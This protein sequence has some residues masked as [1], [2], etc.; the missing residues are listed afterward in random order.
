[1]IC[2]LKFPRLLASFVTFLG[3]LGNPDVILLFIGH[4]KG[5]SLPPDASFAPYWPVK[6][7]ELTGHFLSPCALLPDRPPH[8]R[9]PSPLVAGGGSDAPMAE[10]TGDRHGVDA[11]TQ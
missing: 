11:G 8:P 9:L 10:G 1:M 5:V 7:R 4:G 6:F 2:K 3:N